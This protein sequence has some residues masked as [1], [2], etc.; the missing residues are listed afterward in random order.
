MK[1]F[2]SV[3]N[4]N[5]QLYLDYIKMYAVAVV[6]AKKT[7][8]FIKPY[9]ILDGDVDDE[10]KFLQDLGVHIILYKSYFNDALVNHYKD[11]TIALG[12]FLRVDI[13]KICRAMDIKDE[14]ILYTDMDVMFVSD[15]SKLH[16]LTPTFFCAS[17]EM[18]MSSTP[19]YFNTGVMWINWRNMDTMY[20]SFVS[21]II[22]NLPTFQVYDQDAFNQYYKFRYDYLSYYYNFK[23]YWGFDDDAKII[24]FH[25]PK[26]T[27]QD[28]DLMCFTHPELV[29]PS[30]YKWR[31]VFYQ[32]YNEIK[33]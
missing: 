3:N 28:R 8:P 1:W 22:E 21:F 7:N 19:S 31:D 10:I 11:D 27:T 20:K 6:T 12:A 13:P 18:T 29:T 25:G 26:P 5:R 23:T 4:H 16:D 14:F 32:V 30:F 9:L 2:A 15:V 24:H 17:G 33:R